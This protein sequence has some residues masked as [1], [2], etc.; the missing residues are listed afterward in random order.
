VVYVIREGGKIVYTGI[1]YADRLTKRG[2]EHIAR[3]GADV[4][5]RMEVVTY[6]AQ[7]MD[8]RWAEQAILKKVKPAMNAI[9]SVS[10][11]NPQY[12]ENVD[13]LIRELTDRGFPWK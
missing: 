1:T 8:G 12:R 5:E 9:N 11:T 6:E 3:F 4:R 7:R 10:P 13:R 2:W